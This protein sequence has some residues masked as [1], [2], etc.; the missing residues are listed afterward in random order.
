[1]EREEPSAGLV[2][3]FRDEVCRAWQVGVLEGIVVL[4]VWHS[5]RIE[6]YIDEVEFALHG[7]A[8]RGDEGDR[9]H[10]RTVK[11][12]DRRIV[13]LLAVIAHFVV[14]PRVRFHEACL[15]R[16]L[17]FIEQFCDGT[18]TNFLGTIF[19]TPDRQRR[20]PITRTG[21]IPVVEVI[22][23]LAETSCSS[24]FGLPVDGL[25]E[26]NHLLAGHGGF[27][28]P[29]VERVVEDGF[30]GT[31]AMGVRVH[32]FLCAEETS[33]GFHLQ[34]EVEIKCFCLRSCGFIVLSVD[35][36]LRIIGH[37]HPTA[38]VTA[39]EFVVD[40]R[41]IP[42]FV[43]VFHTPIFAGE[44]DH[45]TRSVVLGLHIETRYAGSVGYFLIVRSESG[46][47]MYDTG[48]VLGGNVVAGYD[49]ESSFA[50]IDPREERFVFKAD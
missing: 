27:D 41:F 42:L 10:V 50:R 23:P 44:I 30:V 45:R 6:P 14:R 20:S 12:N 11:I 36:E 21:E 18:D 43:K 37:F 47:D 25:V 31:P 46:G 40:I 39:V 49:A 13:V 16:F 22:E 17:D 35:G 7:F 3:T 29:R 32:V 34:T 33:V 24:R 26:S 1:M 38:G 28:E 2:H 15:H 4:C 48:S 8:G 19:G 9:V 5:A